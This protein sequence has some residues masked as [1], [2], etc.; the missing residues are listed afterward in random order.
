MDTILALKQYAKKLHDSKAYLENIRKEHLQDISMVHFI[1]GQL[2]QTNVHI[3]DLN[4][5]I[6]GNEEE[7]L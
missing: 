5:I 1:D 7:D 3:M 4:D 6:N 2:H